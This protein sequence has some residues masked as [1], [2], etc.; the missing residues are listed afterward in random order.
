MDEIVKMVADR[1]GIPPDKAR[2]AVDV[3][4]SQLKGRLPAPI[5]SQLDNAL[6]AGGQGGT[7]AGGATGG[8][9]DIG[10]I[11]KGL[12]GMLGDR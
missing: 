3:V 12:G 9:P 11:G 8:M 5:A 7:A 2:M 6:R 1:V 10:S 4:V